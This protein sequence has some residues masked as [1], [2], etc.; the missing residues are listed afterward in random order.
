VKIGLADVADGAGTPGEVLDADGQG[1]RVATGAGAVRFLRL[2]RPG[3]KML[4]AGEFL[5]G[6][7]VSPGTILTSRPM[8][9]LVTA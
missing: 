4:G 2:Q 8:P 9:G 7:P 1:L 3:G 5:R 6:F